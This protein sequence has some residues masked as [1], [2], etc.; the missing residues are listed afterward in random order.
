[1]RRNS[2]IKISPCNLWRIVVLLLFI[3]PGCVEDIPI[4]DT[5]FNIGRLGLSAMYVVRVLNKKMR[6]DYLTFCC[7]CLI[8]LGS[9]IINSGSIAKFVAHFLPAMG[10]LSYMFLHKKDVLTIL[11]TLQNVCWILMIANII[12]FFLFPEGML[13]RE[14]DQLKI[15]LLGQKQDLPGIVIPIL[16][17]SIVLEEKGKS[18][19]FIMTYFLSI[20]TVLLEK[21]IAALACVCFFGLMCCADYWFHVKEKKGRLL[22]ALG[23]ALVALRY[24]S[25]NFKNMNWL[26]KMLLNLNTG[27][28]T[29]VRTLNVRFSMWE[30]AW[31]KFLQ[32]PIIG[33]GEISEKVWVRE[34]GYYHSIVDNMYMDILMWGG[35]AAILLF[36]Y[37]IIKSFVLI[38]KSS[39]TPHYRYLNYLLFALCLYICTG[40]PFAPMVFLVLLSSVWLPYCNVEKIYE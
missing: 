30:Y 25:L 6:R 33:A 21:S 36:M 9:T 22:V 3:K 37:A 20:L 10:L 38:G 39:R 29:K 12:S 8:I 23:S 2:S 1:M 4:L 32:S 5:L 31:S 34:M 24:L 13:Y 19:K 17:V 14:S 40:S 16:F 7:M 11:E 15:W 27:P 28:V 18:K 26:N 35:G